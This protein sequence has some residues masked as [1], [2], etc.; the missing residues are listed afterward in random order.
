MVNKSYISFKKYMDKEFIIHFLPDKLLENFTIK[1]ILLLGNLKTKKMFF[2][3]YLDENNEILIDEI[4]K[5]DY[6]SKDFTVS[7][8]QDF[9][10][11]G[12][13]VYLKIRIGFF[14]R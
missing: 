13:A 3:I 4:D 2:E 7:I 5:K 14:K 11:R 10:N 12:K 6:E 1:N 9:P 8:L